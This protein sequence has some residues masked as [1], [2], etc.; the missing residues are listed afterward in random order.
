MKV[1][2]KILLRQYYCIFLYVAPNIVYYEIL[3]TL[4][5]LNFFM[6]SLVFLSLFYSITFFFG[7]K[8]VLG[9]LLIARDYL[10][11]IH[12]GFI[13]RCMYYLTIKVLQ[14]SADMNQE[15]FYSLVYLYRTS[16]LVS[17]SLQ[18]IFSDT[19]CHMWQTKTMGSS[20]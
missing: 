9:F 3:I 6:T 19:N 16:G 11:V 17:V 14:L 18:L 15:N 10:S 13:S 4:R 20:P 2:W 5:L 7:I 8:N 12:C 1:V